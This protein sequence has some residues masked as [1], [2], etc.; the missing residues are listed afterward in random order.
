MLK[1]DEWYVYIMF[2]VLVYYFIY[3]FLECEDIL[4]KD[5]FFDVYLDNV[6][7]E[8]MRKIW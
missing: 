6:L 7:I 2:W 3:F 1:E 8:L 4:L 5:F